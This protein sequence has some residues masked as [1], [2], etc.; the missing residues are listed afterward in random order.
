M[1]ETRL[2]LEKLLLKTIQ[3]LYHVTSKTPSA[4]LIQV[5]S[6]QAQQAYTYVSI[7]YYV[8]TRGA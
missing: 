2:E 3:I 4:L 6:L 8:N 1:F 7:Y 5:Y